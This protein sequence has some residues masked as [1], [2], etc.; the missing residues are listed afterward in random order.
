M[1]D[2]G[3]VETIQESRDG[4]EYRLD[5][6]SR[7]A[8]VGGGPAGSFFTFFLLNMAETSGISIVVDVYEPRDFAKPSPVGCNMCGGIISE[9][10]VQNLALEGLNLPSRVVQRGIDSYVLHMDVG[11]ARLE[12]P[13]QEMRIGAVTRGPGPRDAKHRDWD[14]FDDHLIGLAQSAGG[15]V[16]RERVEGV[17]VVDERPRIKTKS[18]MS[19]PYDLVAVAI[20]VN[21]PTLRMFEALGIGYER[22]KT[23]K[24]LIR[25]YFLGRD[26]IENCLGS[27]MHVFLLDL[28]RLEFAA[29][30]PKGDYV[31]FCLLGE[32]IDNSVINAFVDSPEVR[33]CMPADWDPKK[34][35]CQCMP[36]INT[37]G[38]SKP[39][40]DRVVFIGDCGITR[41]YKD[42]IGAAYRTAKAAART[43]IF[44]GVSD[45]AF[46]RHYVPVCKNISKDNSIGKLIFVV[47][48]LFQKSRFARRAILRMTMAEQ[49]KAGRHRRMST[50]LWD[51]F[52]GSAPY[53]NVLARTFHPAFVSGL[54]WNLLASLKTVRFPFRLRRT[55]A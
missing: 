36:R 31:T 4:G 44:E 35:S 17:E 41:L 49:S 48:K 46:R 22:P 3:W 23:T 1:A 30:I 14:S 29:V 37:A 5:D 6:L 39:Y 8:V 15:Q 9:T 12:T 42:G 47:T 40:A 28:P 16:I 26:V 21:S 24:T 45:E 20:G 27:S 50:V 19:P 43:A 51:V 52:S 2:E 10:L 54:I 32:E 25:E 55:Q 38:V 7:V 34:R 13:L 53:G 11:S 18:G 33:K